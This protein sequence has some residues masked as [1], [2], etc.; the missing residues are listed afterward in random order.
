MTSPTGPVRAEGDAP[1]DGVHHGFAPD[2]RHRS[3]G[4][5]PPP[6]AEVA[7]QLMADIKATAAT[8]MALLQA[9][10]ALAG[11]GIR[12]AA[13]WGAIA[14]GTVLIAMLAIV[15][16]II[17]ALQPHVGAVLAT[18]IVGAALLAIAAVAGWL[19]RDGARDVKTA[20]T[21]TGDQPH[22]DERR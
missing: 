11:D 2:S 15:F 9:R 3:D 10:G 6:L 13:M 8:E 12:R 19:A 4:D 21:E 16:G 17:L 18:L 5:A 14:G 20:V 1:L 22:W 7:A